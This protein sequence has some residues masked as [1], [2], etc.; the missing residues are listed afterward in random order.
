MVGANREQMLR[1]LGGAISLHNMAWDHVKRNGDA[2]IE[3]EGFKFG[4]WLAD[5]GIGIP[6]RLKS[7]SSDI[8]VNPSLLTEA[9]STEAVRANLMNLVSDLVTNPRGR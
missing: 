1:A 4:G 8:V 5:L 9:Y 2:P 3:V 7:C 6:D